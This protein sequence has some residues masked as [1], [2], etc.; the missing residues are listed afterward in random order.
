MGPGVGRGVGARDGAAVGKADGSGRGTAVGAHVGAA[1]VGAAVGRGDGSGVGA[2]VGSG[3]GSADGRGLGAGVPRAP[4]SPKKGQRIIARCMVKFN[5]ASWRG[6]SAAASRGQ[7]R[8]RL[9]APQEAAEP[10]AR[11]A[12]EGRLLAH[13]RVPALRPRLA[14]Y[15]Y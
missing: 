10:R 7:P 8:G 11:P 1:V 2:G 9:D 5:S 6:T 4:R 15:Y 13:P 12:P 3:V 14:R